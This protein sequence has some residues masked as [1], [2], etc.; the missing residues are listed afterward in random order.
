MEQQKSKTG[1][2]H[3]LGEEA[4]ERNGSKEQH[5]GFRRV[6]DINAID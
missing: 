5:R 1:E 6:K 3:G 4:I 2:S